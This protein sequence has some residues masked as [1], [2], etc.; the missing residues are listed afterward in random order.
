MARHYLLKTFIYLNISTAYEDFS[1]A[2]TM[3]IPGYHHH[4]N[5]L[6]ATVFLIISQ[7]TSNFSRISM[8]LVEVKAAFT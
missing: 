4:M 7:Q 6:S 8:N 3:L 1:N 2:L 5:I